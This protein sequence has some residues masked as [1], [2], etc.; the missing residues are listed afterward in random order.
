MWAVMWTSWPPSIIVL[1]DAR[2]EP[3]VSSISGCLL[4]SQVAPIYQF[5][6]EMEAQS[7]GRGPPLS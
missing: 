5:A 6:A 7:P 3:A 2:A 4:R 1:V